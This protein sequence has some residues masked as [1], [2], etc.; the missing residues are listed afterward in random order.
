M[1]TLITGLYLSC[2]PC[3]V[4]YS[5]FHFSMN[6]WSIIR[7]LHRMFLNPQRMATYMQK[8]FLRTT[9]YG[10]LILA[11]Q[12]H[13]QNLSPPLL[14]HLSQVIFHLIIMLFGL[15]VFLPF[16][17]KRHL[18]YLLFNGM[19]VRYLLPFSILL[20]CAWTTS[21]GLKPSD[22]PHYILV[23]SWTASWSNLNP[24]GQ[25]TWSQKRTVCSKAYRKCENK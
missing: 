2:L 9:S 1:T 12:A 13:L 20:N 11:P 18:S 22:Y 15:T 7:L 6:P 10:K 23:S 4:G 21:G 24:L 8:I 17:E 19:N 16:S 5:Y 25:E 14:R 3:G